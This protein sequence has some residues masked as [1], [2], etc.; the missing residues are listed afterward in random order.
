MYPNKG[1]I[2]I[3][4]ASTLCQTC[5]LIYWMMMMM[6]MVM[7]MMMII[8]IIIIIITPDMNREMQQ[9][10]QRKAYKYL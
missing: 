6:M 10:E 1:V 4:A 5:K 3:N 9:L 2:I 7:M 8:I